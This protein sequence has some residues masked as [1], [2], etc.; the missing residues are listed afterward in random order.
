MVRIKVLYFLSILFFA[1][2]TCVGQPSTNYW[3][4]GYVY[5]TSTEK[6]EQ[7]GMFVPVV[8]SLASAPK[9][10][11]AVSMA[12]GAGFFSFRGTAIDIHK[13][14][15]VT[16]L[17][18][19]KNESYK[20]LRFD[21]APATSGAVSSDVKTRI[22]SDFYTVTKIPLTKQKASTTL[23]TILSRQ[24]SLQ[25]KGGVYYFKGKKG[26][27]SIFVNGK[28]YT[29][30]ELQQ[31]ANKITVEQIATLQLIRLKTVNKFLPGAIDIKLKEGDW[32]SLNEN[33]N[34]VPL[35]KK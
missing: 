11:L 27:P 29:P 19:T 26:V 5:G 13:Q 33:H 28:R 31:V 14:Y 20:C 32:V 4:E 35:S 15:L 18:G 30:N 34:Y 12:D 7:R 23:A 3:Y 6:V 22:R 2:V 17:Y 1:A 9:Q 25:L 8:L 21:T 16:L 10:Y 24:G